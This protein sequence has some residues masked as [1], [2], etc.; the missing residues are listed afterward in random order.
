MGD[1]PSHTDYPPE[2][3]LNRACLPEA[4]YNQGAA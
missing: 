4:A 1:A 2:R 3:D